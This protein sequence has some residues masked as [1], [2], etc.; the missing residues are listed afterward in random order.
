MATPYELDK[1]AWIQQQR[2]E[3]VQE[4]RVWVLKLDGK[5]VAHS[6]SRATIDIISNDLATKG[7]TEIE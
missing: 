5:R 7:Y 2:Q 3:V 6:F 1:A 4:G